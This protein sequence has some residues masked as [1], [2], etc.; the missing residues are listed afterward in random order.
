MAQRLTDL[1]VREVSLVDAPANKGARIALFKRDAT[2]SDY[3]L[4]LEVGKAA[5]HEV[6]EVDAYLKREFSADDRKRLA[7]SGAAMPGG[8]FPIETKAD[9]HNAMQA[10][11]RAK[12]PAKAKAHIKARAKTL[13]LTGELTDAFKSADGIAARIKKFFGEMAAAGQMAVPNAGLAIAFLTNLTKDAA[14][15]DARDFNEVLA[16][17]EAREYARGVLDE[18]DEAMQAL[19]M[20]V[21]EIM[22]DEA[23]TDKQAAIE[24]TFGQFKTHIQGVVPEEL[25]KALTAGIA[26]IA[27]AAGN[28]H[29]GD[30]MSEALKKALGLTAAATEA[31]MIAALTKRD[32]ARQD[33]RQ[34]QGAY[35]RAAGRQEEGLRRDDRR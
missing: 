11:G 15:G 30:T 18:I 33:E 7:S 9:L 6:A 23:T 8:G 17:G 3:D 4:K 24:E 16:E 5:L 29:R 28:P 34:A 13:G 22:C 1:L 27:G 2:V 32:R 10:I 26:A 19:R 12:D 20:A 14:D 21:S 25:E 35:G 31:E